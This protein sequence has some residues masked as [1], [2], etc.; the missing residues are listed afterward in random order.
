MTPLGK[1]IVRGLTMTF[2]GAFVWA[3][4]SSLIGAPRGTGSWSDAGWFPPLGLLY[5][6]W[7]LIPLGILLG[8]ALPRFVR[9]CGAVFAIICAGLIGG[10]IGALAAYLTVTFVWRVAFA[11]YAVTMIP[12]CFLW[13]T[14]WAW[15]LNRRGTNNKET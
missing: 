4:L 6:S 5:M 10:A 8:I 3:V 13:L 7:F 11:Q 14:G 2:P 12:F 15:W 9:R 1:Q